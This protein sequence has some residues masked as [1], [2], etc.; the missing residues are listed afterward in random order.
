[1]S[2]D[3][4]E[5]FFS[6]I[7]RVKAIV[8]GEKIEPKDALEKAALDL[9]E[10][11]LRYY[12]NLLPLIRRNMD[13]L[14]RGTQ[15][16]MKVN[17]RRRIPTLAEYVTLRPVTIFF[18]IIIDVHEPLAGIELPMELRCQTPMRELYEATI[19]I[20]WISN[21]IVSFTKELKDNCTANL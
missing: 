15:W 4:S 9:Q 20:N 16:E 18:N 17:R 19:K 7:E 13:Y 21:D 14:F 2:G 10:D 8:K 11:A 5:Q 3:K 6:R 1:M 12:K